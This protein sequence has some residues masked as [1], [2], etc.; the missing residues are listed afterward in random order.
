MLTGSVPIGS[1]LATTANLNLRTGPGTSYT[2][3]LVIPSGAHV[4]TVNVTAPSNG[5]Y[6]VSYNGVAGWASGSY[7]TLVSSPP[8]TPGFN[9]FSP[10]GAILRATAGVGFSYW[11]GHGAWLQAGPTSSTAGVCSTPVPEGCPN[12][13]HSGSYGAD[14]SGYVAKLWQVPSTN[15]N[16]AADSHPYSTTDFNVDSSLWK[17]I[18]RESLVKGDALVH[19]TNGA[20]HIFLYESGDGWGSMMAYEAKGCV[21]GIVRN[22]RSATTDFHAIRRVGF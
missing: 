4:T 15:T 5:F 16:V 14:C 8:A 1:T 6:N 19:N 13:T 11:W 12:C 18:A 7:L 20:G 10:D 21:Y 9:D 2:V 22:L 17:T 3:R